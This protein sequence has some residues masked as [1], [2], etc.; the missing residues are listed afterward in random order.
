MNIAKLATQGL[1]RLSHKDPV[2][3]KKLDACKSES[4]PPGLI[5]DPHRAN[6]FI[7]E[8]SCEDCGRRSWS[9]NGLGFW[10]TSRWCHVCL[11]ISMSTKEERKWSSFEEKANRQSFLNAGLTSADLKTSFKLDPRLQT[12]TKDESDRH[13]AYLVGS[14]GTGK[15][16]QT[17]QAIKHYV[18]KGWRCRY[19]TETD[20]I[21]LLQEKE[22]TVSMLKD[23][24]L[25]VLDEFGS[26]NPGHWQNDWLRDIV[27]G[28]YRDKKPTIFSSNHSLSTLSTKKGLG[29]IIIERIFERAQEDGSLKSENALYIEFDWSH[30]IGVKAKLPEGCINSPFKH[31]GGPR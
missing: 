17:I 31:D 16:T 18:S 2:A 19:L 10:Y 24:D 14:T 22:L 26:S 5:P 20:M 27:N 4:R 1:N 7:T 3:Q 12:F 6:F 28:R 13:F 8:K 9:S 30:R 21:R 25:L 15:T 23:L 11:D 29:R